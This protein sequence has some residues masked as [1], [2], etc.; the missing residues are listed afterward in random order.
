MTDALTANDLRRLEQT[1]NPG[2]HTLV[3]LLRVSAAQARGG[4]PVSP[5]LLGKRNATYVAGSF[6]PRPDL[7]ARRP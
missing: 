5:N 6:N 4:L 1:N 7:G 3:C 2:R